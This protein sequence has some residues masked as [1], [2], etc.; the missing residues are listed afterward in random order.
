MLWCVTALF[1][2]VGY[3]S[4]ID[5]YNTFKERLQKQKIS[6]LT[7]VLTFDGQEPVLPSDKDTIHLTGGS[8]LWQ[9]ERLLNHAIE[10]L[11]ADCTHFAW[12]DSDLLL[13]F[14]WENILEDQLQK[15]DVVQLFERVVHLKQGEREYGGYRQNFRSGIVWQSKTYGQDWIP[16]RLSG[17]LPHSEPGFGWAAKRTALPALYDR[18][19][20]GGG[21][22]FI[23]DCL[24]NSRP[25]HHYWSKMTPAMVKD[26]DDW[27]GKLTAKTVSYLPIEVYHLW[28]GEIKDRAYHTR[29]MVLKENN[30][31]PVN[32]VKIN[33]HVLEWCSDKPML[34]KGMID[35]FQNRREDGK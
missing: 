13:P 1:N 28:H 24:L 25:L 23:A 31:D 4:R 22:N 6:L 3:R 27:K 11:P 14:G 20:C 16:W 5:N 33:N 32:D 26:M 15:H 29:D 19:I 7:V 9:K 8:I 18:L 30:F 35:Y 12:L 21:D 2:P 17:K 10:S 34:H